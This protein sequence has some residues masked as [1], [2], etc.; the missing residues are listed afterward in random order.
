MANRNEWDWSQGVG[1]RLERIQGTHL[2]AYI[3]GREQ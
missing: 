2:C 3:V 1:Y